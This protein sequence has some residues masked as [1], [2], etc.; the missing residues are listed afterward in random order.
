MPFFESARLSNRTSNRGKIAFSGGKLIAARTSQFSNNPLG[1]SILFWIKVLIDSK[2]EEFPRILDQTPKNVRENP[3]FLRVFARR[4]S[5]ADNTHEGYMRKVEAL[6]KFANKEQLVFLPDSNIF[7]FLKSP[8]LANILKLFLMDKARTKGI[9]KNYIAGFRLA[10]NYALKLFLFNK[11]LDISEFKNYH[12]AICRLFGRK[13]KATQAIPPTIFRLL[14]Q[15]LKKTDEQSFKI[16]YLLFILGTRAGEA[17]DIRKTDIC[18]FKT[19][20]SIGYRINIVRPKT[21]KTTKDDGRTIVF[22]NTKT[23]DET[24]PYLLI[25]YFLTHDPQSKYLVPFY[26]TRSRRLQKLWSWFRNIKINFQTWLLRKHNINYDTSA[27]RIH[28]LRTTLIGFMKL[29]KIPTQVIRHHVGHQYDSEVTEKIY[30]FNCLLSEG[31]NPVFEKSFD[32]V[33]Q[34][35]NLT[36]SGPERKNS[37]KNTPFHL[38]TPPKSFSSSNSLT[39]EDNLAFPFSPPSKRTRLKTNQKK[40]SLNKPRKFFNKL[41]PPRIHKFQLPKNYCPSHSISQSTDGISPI[42]SPLQLNLS[43]VR[44]D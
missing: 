26:G 2:Y 29:S 40:R 25:R 43:S 12:S 16:F 39:S 38:L 41:S 18:N 14:L 44:S 30:F 9:A 20:D 33:L 34:F 36:P 32:R 42:F 6:L 24:N 28:S 15:F 27:W 17:I 19:F 21:Q 4:A 10:I 3:L 37:I 5:V 7:K 1:T 35:S 22:R 8:N 13:A 31:F 23:Q 11:T